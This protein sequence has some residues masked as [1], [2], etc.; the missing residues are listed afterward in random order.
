MVAENGSVAAG[1]DGGVASAVLG[2]ASV[3][4][5]V[6]PSVDAS[7]PSRLEGARDV[8]LRESQLPQLSERHDPMLR[9]RQLGQVMM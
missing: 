6:H 4:H 1:K 9:L 5:C 2:E 8:P 3:A 7:Q